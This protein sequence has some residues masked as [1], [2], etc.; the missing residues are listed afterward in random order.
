MKEEELLLIK[1]GFSAAILNAAM[2][3]FSFMM[4]TGRAV[5]TAIR[6]KFNSSVCS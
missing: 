6:R 4:E 1:G 3:V 2:R 5:G